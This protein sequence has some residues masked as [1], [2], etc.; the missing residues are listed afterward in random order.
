M[1]LSIQ[2]IDIA[3]DSFQVALLQE[4]KQ[5]NRK[6]RNELKGF[7]QLDKWLGKHGVEGLHACL[8]ATGRYWE[9]LAGESCVTNHDI[10]SSLVLTARFRIEQQMGT[11]PYDRDDSHSHSGCR[12]S[13]PLP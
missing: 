4:D 11:S 1:T 8:E 2:G 5:Y 10:H 13:S 7:A 12:K 9:A 6:F 3:R